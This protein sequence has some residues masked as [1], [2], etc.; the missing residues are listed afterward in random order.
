MIVIFTILILPTQEHGI[1]LHLII[2]SLIY[3]ISVLYFSLCSSFVPLG[4]LILRFFILYVAMVNEIDSLIPLSNFSLLVYRNVSDS[5]VLILYPLILSNTVISSSDFLIVSLGFSMYSVMSSA[6]SEIFTF[7]FLIWIP[8]ISLSS[9]IAV[10]RISK[11]MLNNSGESGHPYLFTDL[12]GNA[13]NFSPIKNNIC[14][15]LIIYGH[16]YVELGS[17]YA[18]F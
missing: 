2:S 4:K 14:C 5:S 9:L 10:A 7:S 3:L 15:R 8:F 17:L 1:Y 18:Q 11:T 6:N 16:Y 13:F 12:R